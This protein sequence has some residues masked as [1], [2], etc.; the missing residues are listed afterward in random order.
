M[1]ERERGES[2]VDQLCLAVEPPDRQQPLGEGTFGIVPG[3]RG[4]AD[5][6]RPRPGGP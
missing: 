6:L 1:A 2:T 5:P 3:D 4:Q